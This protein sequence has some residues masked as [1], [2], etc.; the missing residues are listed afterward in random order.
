MLTIVG[1][2]RW[3]GNALARRSDRREAWL[4]LWAAVLMAVGVPL[5][6][7]AA[8]E[9]THDAMLRTA[10]EQQ[11]DRQRT[12]A[13][14]QHVIVRPPL[15]S[16]TETSAGQQPN[17]NQVTAR[18]A[19]PDGSSHTG[20]LVLRRPVKPGS[21]FLVWTDRHGRLTSRPMSARGASSHALLAGL[22][23]AALTAA[24]LEAGRRAA[25]RLALRRR[26]A[27]WDEE[28]GRI[29]PDWGRTGNSS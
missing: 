16:E 18:W 9:A 10:H 17:R 7:W 12:W 25:I 26:Y 6:G 4:S 24:V 11:R 8:Q 5:V 22:G 21:R 23:S 20:T 29:G 27:R 1:L 19:G 2:W 13:T 3:R 14:A 28:W 15:D